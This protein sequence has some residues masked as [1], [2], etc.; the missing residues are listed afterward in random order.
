[1]HVQ[2]S[3]C[4]SKQYCADNDVHLNDICPHLSRQVLWAWIDV[5]ERL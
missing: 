5:D 4:E 3:K 1:M 2:L